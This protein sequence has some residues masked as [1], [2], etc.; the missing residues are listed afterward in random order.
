MDFIE[1]MGPV[2][3]A[4]A[5]PTERACRRP[6]RAVKG[7]RFPWAS[8]DKFVLHMA[9]FKVVKLKYPHVQNELL[10]WDRSIHPGK[11]VG[12]CEYASCLSN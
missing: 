1:A 12:K 10:L 11:V 8:I 4:W 2:W 7:Q 9:Q 3:A 5:F 6:G